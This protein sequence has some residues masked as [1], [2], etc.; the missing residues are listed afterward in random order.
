MTFDEIIEKIETGELWG[1]YAAYVM[2]NS[3]GDRVICNSRTLTSAMEDG[4]L[5]DDFVNSRLEA[6]S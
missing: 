2:E 6:R 4:Y 3:K 1:D 5:L